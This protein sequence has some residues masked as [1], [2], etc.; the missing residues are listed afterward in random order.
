MIVL[1]N[2]FSEKGSGGEREYIEGNSPLSREKLPESSRYLTKRLL[3]YYLK[4]EVLPSLG[5]KDKWTKHG[6]SM[7]SEVMAR[8]KVSF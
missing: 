8:F 4:L 7:N 3:Q 2:L 5:V 6:I 1:S